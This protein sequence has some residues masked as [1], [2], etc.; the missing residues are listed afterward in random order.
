M[1]NLF[2]ILLF[3]LIL[4]AQ[5]RV[6]TKAL[7]WK[8]EHVS[9]GFFNHKTGT[10]F[11]SYTRNILRNKNFNQKREYF[12]ALGTNIFQNTLSFGVKQN[13]LTSDMSK[14]LYSSFAIQG[15]YGVGNRSD[16]IAPCISIGLDIPM[17]Y[18]KQYYSYPKHP[19]VWPL[20]PFHYIKNEIDELLNK[21]PHEIHQ[22]E[23]INIGVSSSFY[24]NENNVRLITFPYLY[25]SYRW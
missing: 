23:F 4:F 15:V 14:N 12:I 1:K 24:F 10:S 7:S 9:I 8:K 5:S 3:P 13:I 6:N 11:I 19:I 20:S 17:A 18:H 21:T 16:F 25:L 2:I 22:K